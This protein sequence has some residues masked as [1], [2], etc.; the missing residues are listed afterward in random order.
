MLKLV[1]PQNLL[2]KEQYADLPPFQ[3][4][5]YLSNLLKQI[6]EL[7]PQGVTISQVDKAVKLG[8]STIWHHLENLADSAFCLKMERGDTA[9]YNF[10]KIVHALEDTH[11]QGKFYYYDFDLVE[12]IFGKFVRMQIK[13]EDSSGNLVAN[14]G[15]LVGTNSFDKVVGSFIKIRDVHLIKDKN[16]EFFGDIAKPKPKESN[17]NDGE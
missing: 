3:K 2:T 7:N 15:V 5:E 8:H 6:L 13:Q 17:L 12:N 10:N 11:V 14:G 9:V 16:K 1:L 4:G